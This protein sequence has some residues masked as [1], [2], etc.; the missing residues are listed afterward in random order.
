MRGRT[1]QSAENTQQLLYLTKRCYKA[2]YAFYQSSPALQLHQALRTLIRALMV[3]IAHAHICP[4][5]SYYRYIA[6]AAECLRSAATHKDPDAARSFSNCFLRDDGS[7]GIEIFD[8]DPLPSDAELF[9]EI[10]KA[11]CEPGDEAVMTAVFY[12]TM[13]LEWI[14]A[15]YESLLDTCIVPVSGGNDL[16]HTTR[17]KRG[18]Y[19]TPPV[20]I[21]YVIKTTLDLLVPNRDLCSEEL[22]QIRILDP[23]MGS[24]GFL[25]RSIGLMADILG[26]AEFSSKLAKTCVY[27]VDVDL[28][29]C[30]IA[31]F[32]VWAK[33]GFADGVQ[34]ALKQHMIRGDA[35]AGDIPRP[36]PAS[37]THPD[38]Q[39][40]DAV[41]GNPP[42][43]ASKNY[44]IPQHDT[45]MAGQIDTYLLFLEMVF[46]RRLVR[47][48]GVLAMVLPDPLLVRGNA[49]KVRRILARDWDIKSIVHIYGAF[50]GARV[51]NVLLIAKN[52]LP[53]SASFVVSR[54]DRLSQ[55]RDF[56]KDPIGATR[57]L[58][59][60]LSRNVALAQKRCEL[61]YLL[62]EEPFV[63]LIR[64]I[65][66]PDLSLLRYRPPFA[67]LE[68]LNVRAIYRGEEIGKSNIRSQTGDLPILLGG[69]S[70]RPYEILWEGFRIDSS[71]VQ[72]PLERYKCSKILV[73]KSAGLTVAAFDEVKGR[74]LGYVF[75]QSVYAVEL[76]ESG[77]SHFY[78]LCLLNS[79][80]IGEY[81]RRTATGY[82]LVQP[83]IE[84]ED[85][86]ALPIR[87]IIFTT[88]SRMRK[89]E[90]AR[91]STLFADECLRAD[92]ST[93]FPELC[94]FVRWCLKSNPEMSDVVHDIL[95]HL[96]RLAVELSRKSRVSPS[97]QCTHQLKCVRSAVDAVVW[98]L[99]GCEPVQGSLGV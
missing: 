19:F 75:P 94:E 80:L 76:D 34:N 61:L 85:L 52:E 95:V 12:E 9:A 64:K 86:R 84:I 47:P 81:V 87:R 33:T 42:Y 41:V 20:V 49:E 83:Q 72:K 35:L 40:F 48:G 82:K 92:E 70:I 58:G 44:L 71:R 56:M 25:A 67:P 46:E 37:Q 18:V 88:P 96:G 23:A 99:Y 74:H 32:C 6:T 66:G 8:A 29:A 93:S 63:E 45:K 77:I 53:I 28:I 39:C 24:G 55:R 21:D 62:E 2:L 50:R 38:G 59:R 51:A 27:G 54:I 78:L 4:G 16:R 79:S 57:V 17:K 68:K 3:M 22:R 43:L 91:A 30:E 7:P 98:Q 89:N 97:S 69:Q 14:G 1:T 65:H 26:S 13:P 31:R 5:H 15:V 90:L 10:A 73:Q 11:L 36:E 60:R